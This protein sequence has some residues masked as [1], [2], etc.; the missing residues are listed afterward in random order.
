MIKYEKDRVRQNAHLGCSAL[1]I[2]IGEKGKYTKQEKKS[3]YGIRRV[4]YLVNDGFLKPTLIY[5][6]RVFAL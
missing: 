4:T 5:R 6:L 2:I 3:V 1:R